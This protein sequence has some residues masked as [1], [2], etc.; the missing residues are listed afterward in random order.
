MDTCSP[1]HTALGFLTH[2]LVASASSAATAPFPS[3]AGSVSGASYRGTLTGRHQ[4]R[5]ALP[6]STA[7]H[8]VALLSRPPPMAFSFYM[9]GYP[10]PRLNESSHNYNRNFAR[11]RQTGFAAVCCPPVSAPLPA[12]LATSCLASRSPAR[13]RSTVRPGAA[14]M[15]SLCI[16]LARA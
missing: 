16:R 3:R 11:R 6:A 4:A 14:Y 7:S 12:T 10:L 5:G 9:N 2:I 1:R 8:A 13:Q 15:L